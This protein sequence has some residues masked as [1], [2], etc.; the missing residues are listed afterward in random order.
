MS[1][2]T[3]SLNHSR[4][5]APL[6]GLTHVS[7][8]HIDQWFTQAR[9]GQGIQKITRAFVPPL[10][11]LGQTLPAPLLSGLLVLGTLVLFWLLSWQST[12]V[13]GIIT[14]VLLG[15]SLL[16]GIFS[17]LASKSRI[18]VVDLIIL[19]FLGSALLSTAFSSYVST[20]LIGLAKWMTFL[21]GYV[22]F[23]VLVEVSGRHG[24]IIALVAL[25]LIGLGQSLIGF[26]QY[27]HHI[28]PLATWTD[29]TVNPELKLTRI[30]GTLQPYN[31]NLLAGFLIPCFAAAT[32]LSLYWLRKRTWPFALVCLA[33]GGAI[34]VAIV[35]TGSRGGY[36]ALAGMLAFLFASVGHLL[37]HQSELQRQRW[38]K[39][40][41]L[42]ILIGG[43][44][45]VMGGVMSS[46][47]IQHRLA[48]IFAMREDS[49]I[50]Y[51]LNVYQS[52]TRMFLDNPVVG[53]GPGNNTFKQV[54]GL[55]MVPG[56]NALGAYS[57]P[58]E[59][60]VEQGAI[61]LVVFLVLLA[62]LKFRTLFFL[63]TSV[64]LTD[65]WLAILLFTGVVGSFIYGFFDTIWYRPAV[66]LLFWFLVAALAWLSEQMYQGKCP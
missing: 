9:T 45:A 1:W 26:Y 49:S 23:R 32:G 37:W 7:A 14:G 66:N 5:L 18:T 58:L 25:M 22:S 60:A 2:F 33:A 39:A 64:A 3:N 21:A 30:F 41:W 28:E 11:R 16:I 50:S 59:I 29:P 53:I 43:V 63:D 47:K 51:R 38:L 44:L 27:T 35:L 20:S 34:L 24:L 62:V 55:Y 40:L 6:V 31:P 48:S 57:V 13:I 61:G 15:F 4:L 52:A 46:P 36:L 42:I 54:Y 19:A 65:K 56:Y 17:G 10:E 8:H 12:T